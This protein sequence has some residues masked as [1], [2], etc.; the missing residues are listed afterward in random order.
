MEES[1][2]AGHSEERFEIHRL[3]SG[4]SPQEQV[5]IC[6]T[7]SAQRKVVIATEIAETGVTVVGV[8]FVLDT[9]LV[10]QPMFDSITG[11]TTLVRTNISRATARKQAERAG[12]EGPG[13]VYRLYTEEDYK[14]MQPH[15]PA[16][17]VI[18]EPAELIF[19]LLRLKVVNILGFC[20]EFLESPSEGS[21]LCGMNRLFQLK[22]L[23]GIEGNLT[24]IGKNALRFPQL[25]HR[26]AV[27]IAHGLEH[28][29][30][31]APL[32]S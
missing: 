11:I 4:L 24:E 19:Q 14:K 16:G 12:R 6:E 15:T 3:H 28:P 30:V 23:E 1:L 13:T 31:L 21:L 10:N 26:A 27:A 9:G 32:P 22:I 8:R 25:S 18:E 20:K 5:A 7:R 17:V 2:T 29:E